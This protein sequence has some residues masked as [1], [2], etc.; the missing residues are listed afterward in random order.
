MKKRTSK[1]KESSK[2]TGKR[3]GR[4][5]RAQRGFEG[6]T[7]GLKAR[8]A[9]DPRGKLFRDPVH[10]LIEIHDAFLLDLI[11]A[12]EFQR[13]RRIRQLG[14]GSLTYHGAEHTRFAH[15]LGVLNFA[16]R[17]L[18]RLRTRYDGNR[19]V[20]ELL[21]EHER[22]VKAAALL[23]DIGHGAFSHML[24]RAFKA[25][26]DHEKKT[27]EIITSEEFSI[28]ARLR[29]HDLDP[30]RVRSIID[31]S[32]EVWFL[33]DIVSSQLDA[34]RMDYLLR[35]ALMSG[36]EYGRYDA[37]WILNSLCLGSEPDPNVEISPQHWRLCLDQKRGLYSA[38]QLIVA[39]MHMSLQVYYHPVTRG[40]ETHLLCLFK[41]AGNLA[42]SGHLP[43]ETP[44]ALTAFFNNQ[45]A[46]SADEF[47]QIDEALFQTGF[48]TWARSNDPR[49]KKLASLARSFL[50]RRKQF[51]VRDVPVSFTDSARLFMK[52]GRMG[53][54]DV[55]W[56]LDEAGFRSY[57][58]FG[59]ILS[60]SEA[61]EDA[62]SVSTEA[63]LLSNG[64]PNQR[65]K[66]A[67][68]DERSILF[69]PM[70]KKPINLRRLYFHESIA[71]QVN[72]L[73]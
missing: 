41:E 50:E 61:D 37:E 29:A 47:L 58:D 18:R 45:G 16:Q 28:A 15:S 67:E 11:D 52:L 73:A 23:H 5:S 27:A 42:A 65:A 39:R 22:T 36:V 10:G 25:T 46:V 30:D 57:K 64:D 19:A 63:I 8:P 48:Q 59:A 13:L 72:A 70:G 17:I 56:R 49:H 38:E 21:N 68:R 51:F 6:A 34:D 69:E 31:K 43:A 35:D 26:T 20:A 9:L 55:D 2:K 66:P 44:N 33:K 40:W 53:R 3:T 14:V 1:A 62:G 32:F 71:Q 12:P 54:E 4:Q 60:H 7:G 24:E